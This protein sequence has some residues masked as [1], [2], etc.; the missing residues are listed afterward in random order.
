MGTRAESE[1]AIS[2]ED[3]LID[4][5]NAIESDDSGYWTNKKIS[6]AIRNI[7]HFKEEKR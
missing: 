4:L 1:D 2:R 5:A 6:S 7:L 3:R